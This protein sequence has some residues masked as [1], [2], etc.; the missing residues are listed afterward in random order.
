MS[1]QSVGT[2][3][4]INGKETTL[5][6]VAYSHFLTFVRYMYPKYEA[7][8]FHKEIAAKLEQVEKGNCRRL[9]IQMHP[10]SGKSRLVS[11]LFVP[12]FMGRNPDKEVIQAGYSDEFAAKYGEQVRE[13]IKDPNFQ[14][15]FQDVYLS[16]STSA[17]DHF[18]LDHPGVSL[19]QERGVYKSAG[20][21]SATVG[22]G[23]DLLVIDDPCKT[24]EEADSPAVRQKIKDWFSSVVATRVYKN[25]AIVIIMQRWHD[26]DLVGWILRELKFEGW[27]LLDFPAEDINGKKDEDGDGPFIWEE[28][29]GRKYYKEAKRRNKRDWFSLYQQ[30]PIIESG[31]IFSRAHMKIHS[32]DR[33]MPNFNYVIDCWDTAFSEQST[34]DFS[35]KVTLGVFNPRETYNNDALPTSAAMLLHCWRKQAGFHDVRRAMAENYRASYGANKKRV[36]LILVEDKA[37]GQSLKKELYRAGFPWYAP[38]V[39]KGERGIV[40]AHSVTPIM[41]SGYFYAPSD[42]E[43]DEQMFEWMQEMLGYDK[44][45]HDDY[46]DATVHGLRYLSDLGFAV[47]SQLVQAEPEDEDDLSWAAEGDRKNPYFQ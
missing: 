1:Q 4:I 43:N 38:K 47:S 44:K 29:F 41:E 13:F 31:N 39:R 6:A 26:D 11:E 15:I 14:K 28:R 23:A 45:E 27:E 16:D 21:G 24:R 35:A 9:I 33:G 40:R 7:A 5:E 37:S 12:W 46:V 3:I 2:K 36:D 19:R 22:F 25:S 10:R 18:K 30:T 20:V 32:V 42:W 8:W 34:A 17:K